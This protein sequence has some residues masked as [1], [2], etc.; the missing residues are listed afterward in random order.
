M[1]ETSLRRV[2]ELFLNSMS[3]P[4]QL[5]WDGWLL[6]FAPNDVKRARS[7]NRFATS[8]Q[9]IEDQV[10][11]IEMFYR[12]RGLAPLYRITSLEEPGLDAALEGRKYRRFD[13]SIVMIA[14]LKEPSSPPGADLRFEMVDARRLVQ[15]CGAMR[16]S[17]DPAIAAHLRRLSYGPLPQ[18]RLLA[19]Q[20]DVL[21]GGGL[22]MREDEW[23]GL[24]DVHIEAAQRNRGIGT[25]LC[26][27]L[28]EQA[29]LWGSERA[30]LAVEA[31]NDAALTVYT[32]LGFLEA[33]RY[34]YREAIDP[35]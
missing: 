19:W 24:F 22:S 26:A 28:M 25:A 13:E 21:A 35:E 6:R 15:E 2:E 30:W 5:L 34:W 1:P 20:D 4:E 7:A 9:P 17:E 32:R 14:E 23:V 18:F 3:V 27:Y 33:Y 29:R 12:E 11:H 31:S 16:H 8:A 10:D